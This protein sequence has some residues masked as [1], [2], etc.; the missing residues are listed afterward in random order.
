MFHIMDI[1]SSDSPSPVSL[2]QTLFYY[3]NQNDTWHIKL[4][5]RIDLDLCVPRFRNMPRSLLLL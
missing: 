5:V 1:C 2:V 4:T 3:A